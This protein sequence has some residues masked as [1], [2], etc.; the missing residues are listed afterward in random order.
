MKTWVLVSFTSFYHSSVISPLIL[1]LGKAESCAMHAVCLETEIYGKHQLVHSGTL[2]LIRRKP[3]LEESGCHQA[4]CSRSAGKSAFNPFWEFASFALI[5]EGFLHTKS[6]I[7]RRR[8]FQA[9]ATIK[10][11]C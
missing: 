11:G 8:P 2:Q 3:P 6:D 1:A 5:A 10:E 4:I 7:S 9:H